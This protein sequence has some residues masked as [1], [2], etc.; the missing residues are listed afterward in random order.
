MFLLIS[1]ASIW[2]SG[3][4]TEELIKKLKHDN[5]AVRVNAIWKLGKI[6]LE[7]KGRYQFLPNHY[8][9]ETI[10]F[11]LTQQRHSRK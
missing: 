1:S 9:M 4:Q 2:I 5:P 6:G 10:G 11:V 8:K 7:A 3:C